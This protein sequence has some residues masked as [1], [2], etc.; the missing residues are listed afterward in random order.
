[1]QLKW[2]QAKHR[3]RECNYILL[4]LKCGRFAIDWFHWLVEQTVQNVLQLLQLAFWCI[5]N[6]WRSKEEFSIRISQKQMEFDSWLAWVV[7]GNGQNCFNLLVSEASVWIFS[8]FS[9]SI[10]SDADNKTLIQ[11]EIVAAHDFFLLQHFFL[12]L[13][14]CIQTL[15]YAISWCVFLSLLK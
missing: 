6:D 4:I 2:I 13:L 12:L 10:M 1:M 3:S 5:R 7:K 14:F 15:G 8:Q 11:I 9:V